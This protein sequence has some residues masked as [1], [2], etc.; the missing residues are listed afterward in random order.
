MHGVLV[1][2]RD[3]VASLYPVPDGVHLSAEAAIALAQAISVVGQARD[4]LGRDIGSAEWRA[5]T[6]SV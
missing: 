5:K 1:Q 3:L 2:A 6:G 4:L